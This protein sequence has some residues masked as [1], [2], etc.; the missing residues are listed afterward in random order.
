[1]HLGP[2]ATV[3]LQPTFTGPQITS[4]LQPNITG[5]QP[6]FRPQPPLQSQGQN[7]PVFQQQSLGHR[8]N[9]LS[10]PPQAMVHGGGVHTQ[11]QTPSNQPAMAQQF[12]GQPF[13]GQPMYTGQ[14]LPGYPQP[15]A[16][17]QFMMQQYPGQPY[18]GQYPVNAV[19]PQMTQMMPGLQMQQTGQGKPRQF[20]HATPLQSLNRGPAPVD[21]PVCSERAMTNIHFEVGNTTQ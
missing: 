4:Q 11:F 10:Q 18:P 21:C 8:P 19:Q 9:Q 14:M 20:M 13:I 1:M 15:V 16:G 12:T 6:T 5:P 7:Q 2:Q 17:Q 3:Q